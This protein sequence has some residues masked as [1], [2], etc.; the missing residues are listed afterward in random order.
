MLYFKK[1]NY[2][3]CKLNPSTFTFVEVLSGIDQARVVTITNE[4]LYNQ[5]YQ[6]IQDHDFEVTTEEDFTAFLTVVLTRLGS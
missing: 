6:R 4:E 1:Q 3:Y 2:F 5:T